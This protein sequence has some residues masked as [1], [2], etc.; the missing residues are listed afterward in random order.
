MMLA[1]LNI[2]PNHMGAK[3]YLHLHFSTNKVDMSLYANQPFEYPHTQIA[4]SF[5][6]PIVQFLKL[7]FPSFL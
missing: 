3:C 6:L 4:Y 1:N 7:E 5:P 2:I